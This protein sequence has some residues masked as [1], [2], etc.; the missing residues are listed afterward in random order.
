MCAASVSMI[1]YDQC[2]DV[3]P[4]GFAGTVSAALRTV[5]HASQHSRGV[6][7]LLTDARR[8]FA[9]CNLLALLVRAHH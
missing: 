7:Q 6:A 4:R 1:Q 3:S 5:H 8:L 2:I 9:G